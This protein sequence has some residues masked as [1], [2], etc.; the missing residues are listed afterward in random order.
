MLERIGSVLITPLSATVIGTE[1]QLHSF[2]ISLLISSNYLGRRKK[3]LG[4]SIYY[5]T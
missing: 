2:V 1:Y 3:L 4:P 5:I